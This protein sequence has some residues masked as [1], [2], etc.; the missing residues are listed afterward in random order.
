MLDP[1]SYSHILIIKHTPQVYSEPTCD[2]KLLNDFVSELFTNNNDPNFN[3]TPHY[4]WCDTDDTI[5]ANYGHIFNWCFI[6]IN[7]VLCSE[8][9]MLQLISQSIESLKLKYK[10][11]PLLKLR[12]G[13]A[14][15][16]WS[17]VKQCINKA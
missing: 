14:K 1:T 7:N 11:D 2:H 12:P 4:I 13:Y 5:E 6:G 17:L 16:Y 9:A 3:V 10:N 15:I 8:A